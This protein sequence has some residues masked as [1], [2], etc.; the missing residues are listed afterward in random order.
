MG[1]ASRV[2]P[3][4]RSK[5]GTWQRLLALA[6]SKG[7]APKRLADAVEGLQAAFSALHIDELVEHLE[8]E[9]PKLFQ[10]FP[11]GSL[12]LVATE[13]LLLSRLIVTHG[14]SS[15]YL[16]SDMPMGQSD[17][18]GFSSLDEHGL[19]R[20]VS[21]APLMTPLLLSLPNAALGYAFDLQ[22]QALV[23]LFGEPESLVHDPV[24]LPFSAL[25]DPGNFA[26]VDPANWIDHSIYARLGGHDAE[27]LLQWWV[28]QLN[29]F[30]TYMID[31][32][33]FQIEE[34]GLAEPR[35]QRAYMLTFERML[36]DAISAV[37]G[38]HKS[39]FDRLNAAF[40]FLD[41]AEAL[42]GYGR[43]SSGR[44]FKT[45]VTRG[46][47]L[48]QLERHFRSSMPDNLRKP[49]FRY[50]T[51]LF[52]QVCH[53]VRDGVVEFRRQENAILVGAGGG[54]DPH[55]KPHD[56]YTALLIRA[57]RDSAH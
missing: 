8:S 38:I 32:R 40:D 25:Y 50:A 53:E 31:P 26:P 36:A 51:D 5:R 37:G 46:V 11:N 54:G 16:A 1:P 41:K 55:H 49:L 20:G 56:D 23:L 35:D 2:P 57:V 47:V 15:L 4:P 27:E 34:I 44:G 48:R 21:F 52:N 14:I 22:P 43:R 19:T 6:E 39:T 45:L 9:L 10:L 12:W 18:A 30:Y 17:F 28:G 24:P 3:L 13:P 29:V 42:L 33:N 7:P